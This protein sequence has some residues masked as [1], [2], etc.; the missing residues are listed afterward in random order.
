MI[1]MLVLRPR[2]GLRAGAAPDP[3]DVAHLTL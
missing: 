3:T 2:H 1:K